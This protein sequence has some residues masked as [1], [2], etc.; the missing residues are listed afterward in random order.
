MRRACASHILTDSFPVDP[1]NPTP[2]TAAPAPG[3]EDDAALQPRLGHVSMVTCVGFLGAAGSPPAHVVTCDR[4]EHIRISRWGQK[5]AGYVI[6][7]YLLGSR[8][9]VGALAVLPSPL[10]EHAAL[11]TGAN[12]ALLTSDGG[13]GL[14]LWV[15]GADGRY[16]QHTTLALDRETLAGSVRVDGDVERR[17]EKAASNPA[18]KGV[19]DP[20]EAAADEANK[21][22]KRSD[23]AAVPPPGGAASVPTLVI[24]KLLPFVA[25]GRAYVLIALEGATAFFTVP[26][27]ALAPGSASSH[28]IAR[29]ELW[30]C[31]LGAPILDLALVGAESPCVWACCDDR[32]G[33]G[34]GP[35]LHQC[36]W[37]AE[38]VRWRLCNAIADRQFVETPAKAGT[39]LS[40]FIETPAQAHAPR[41]QGTLLAHQAS[42]YTA[43]SAAE[44]SKL[45]YYQ[46]L[47]TWPK[48][49]PAGEH[50]S[51]APFTSFYLSQR[52]GP[53]AQDM[54]HRFQSGKRAAGRA[55]NQAAIQ[56][57]FGGKPDSDA[58]PSA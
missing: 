47:M 19:F 25:A 58:Q 4:D 45:C 24:T 54:L 12:E 23:G 48:P 38:K 18:F 57:R 32:P 50:D 46:A 14:R 30:A 40:P 15:M 31:D 21:R 52:P 3:E 33:F 55:K 39:E 27:D 8:A 20:S 36:S 29:E 22:Q 56:E 37:A 10:T 6:E 26:L 11:Q 7:Q 51:N 44:L 2:A 16:K 42:A 17:R 5:R 49:P 41:A 34:H 43:A 53:V 28:P 1:A 13:E 9:F 35:T